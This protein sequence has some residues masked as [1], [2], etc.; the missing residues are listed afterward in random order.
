MLRLG[1]IAGL[2]RRA[3]VALPLVAL[4]AIT[5]TAAYAGLVS[6]VSCEE[7]PESSALALSIK[8]PGYAY[9]LNDDDPGGK[10]IVYT[11]QISTGKIVGRI[12]LKNVAPVDPE[13][14]SL[15]RGGR[16][17]FADVGKDERNFT[18]EPPTLWMFT[19]PSTPAADY[20][21][22]PRAYVLAYPPGKEWD[23]ETLLINPQTNA[24]YLVTKEQ[25]DKGKRLALPSP[26]SSTSPNL[27]KVRE[28]LTNKVS[29]G[30]FTPNGKWA[31]IRSSKK[32]YVYYPSAPWRLHASFDL[33]SMHQ[34]ESLSF[35]PKGNR[36][37]VGSECAST[38]TTSPLYWIQFDQ[39]KG[40]QPK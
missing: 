9:T 20:E 26:L 4:L 17:W 19:E 32:A 24:R 10:A 12:T 8:H 3:L 37:L 38:D 21:V 5:S 14:L 31:V 13:A 7:I 25:D 22:S 30:S 29:D 39:A 34:P 1:G 28:E 11:I 6:R 2:R 16:M 33:P 18:T 36:F 40:D 35:D 27:V 23:V 15:D